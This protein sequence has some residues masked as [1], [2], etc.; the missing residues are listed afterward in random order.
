MWQQGSLLNSTFNI[1]RQEV[2]DNYFMNGDTI[3]LVTENDF[4]LDTSTNPLRVRPRDK[5]VE[6]EDFWM[7]TTIENHGYGEQLRKY[8][9]FIGL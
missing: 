9:G 1:L 5:I 4:Y 6:N 2:Y 8:E 7:K 3:A